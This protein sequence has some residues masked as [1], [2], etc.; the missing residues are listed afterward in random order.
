MPLDRERKLSRRALPVLGL[1]YLPSKAN[2]Y[3][4]L[5]EDAGDVAAYLRGRDTGEGLLGFVAW[6]TATSGLR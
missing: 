1:S 5:L 6:V 2:F 4:L 3:L